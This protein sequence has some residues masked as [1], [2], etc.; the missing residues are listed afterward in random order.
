MGVMADKTLRELAKAAGIEDV[1]SA[2]MAAALDNMPELALPR[3]RDEFLLPLRSSLTNAAAGPAFTAAEKGEDGDGVQ[4]EPLVYMCG[5][6]LGLQPKRTRSLIAEELGVWARQGVSGH[7]AH[8][9]GRPWKDIT[10][11]VTASVARLVGA[12]YETEVA[13]M[14]SLTANLHALMSSFYRPS[15]ERTKICIEQKAFPS[16]EYAMQ[17]QCRLH[18]LDPAVHL[19]HICPRAGEAHLRTDDVLA[20]IRAHGREIAVLCLS[21]VQYYTG[22]YFDIP[23]ITAAA[24]DQGCVVGWDLAHA[25]GNLPLQLH[26]WQV[27]FAAWCHYKYVNA[28]PG[29]IAG[30]FVH[31]D[32]RY[33]AEAQREPVNDTGGHSSEGDSGRGSGGGVAYDGSPVTSSYAARLQGWWGHDPATRFDMPPAFSPS[34]GAWGYQLSNPS[35]LDVVALLASMQVFDSTSMVELRR[36]SVLMTTMLLE[37]LTN[38][39]AYRRAG[40]RDGDGDAISSATT[41]GG[42]SGTAASECKRD[43][44]GGGNA[45]TAVTFSILTPHN[46]RSLSDASQRGSQVSL[47]FSP[48]AAMPA[49]MARLLERAVVADERRPAVIRISPA[50]SY[51]TFRDTHAA[52]W[53]LRDVVESLTVDELDNDNDGSARAAEGG[54]G[55]TAGTSGETRASSGT[56]ALLETS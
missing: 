21:G 44:S 8:P 25:V 26:D 31:T 23:A 14:G 56:T 36:K 11:C 52:G 28:G 49:V 51:C 30:I 53:A 50:A 7:F 45:G 16:D 54:E 5:N 3:L 9:L 32:A 41:T 37:I 15:G 40:D 34:P 20:F 12:R 6:S 47:S 35:V 39:P 24:H 4:D 42:G 38:S 55:R 22:Q 43:D 2:A 46:A 18:G 1:T 29:A 10:D 33:P 17:S 27:D 19:L 13:V 48:A